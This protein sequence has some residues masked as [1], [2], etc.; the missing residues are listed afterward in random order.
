MKDSPGF[1]NQIL[2]GKW[3]CSTHGSFI[4]PGGGYDSWQ[5]NSDIVNKLVKEYIKNYHTREGQMLKTFES[6]FM[7]QEYCKNNDIQL[8]NFKAWDHDLFRTDYK[9]TKHIQALIDKDN[10]WFYNGKAG[11]KEWCHDKGD[12][13]MPGGHPQSEFQYLFTISVIEPWLEEQTF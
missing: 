11:L 3:H 12:D 13:V 8:L 5:S 9:M 4:K 7:V 10:W 2:T 6:I 1:T